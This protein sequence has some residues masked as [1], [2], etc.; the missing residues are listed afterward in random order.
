MNKTVLAC[1][2]TG[3]VTAVIGAAIG[4]QHALKKLT[5]EFE[6]RLDD[7]IDAAKEYYAKVNKAEDYESVEAA[8]AKLLPEGLP[9]RTPKI[10]PGVSPD[11]PEYPETDP[12]LLDS[13]VKGLRYKNQEELPEQWEVTETPMEDQDVTEEVFEEAPAIPPMDTTTHRD[14][15][16]II[17]VETLG[18]K[19]YHTPQLF[20]YTGNKKLIDSNNADVDKALVGIWNL[21]KF[22][23][24]S[25]SI[26][27]VYVRNDDLGCDFEIE[28]IEES[29]EA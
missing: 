27:H 8:A 7:E 28:K 12:D 11:D 21:D 17:P 20:Y 10:P 26:N 14:E 19:D 13:I 23:H 5:H 3:L 22:G 1:A 4:Y 2:G 6:M 24:M 9:K 15:P 16:Y 25:N 18:E 29:F